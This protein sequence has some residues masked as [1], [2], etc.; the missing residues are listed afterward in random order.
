MAKS[1]S[2]ADQ[3]V[4]S[5]AYSPAI[6]RQQKFLFELNRPLDDLR[7]MLLETFAGKTLTMREIYEEHS[8]DRPFLSK[9]YKDVL[10]ALEKAQ[11]IKTQGR[12]S[13]RGFAD[14]I[15]VTFPPRGS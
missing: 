6:D 14:D 13:G 1:S 8:V 3:N 11:T 12:R 10:A 2:T 5:F 4:P 15:V 9:N 7:A